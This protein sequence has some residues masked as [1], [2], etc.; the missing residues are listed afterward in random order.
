[1]LL[2]DANLRP[3]CKEI[4]EYE[5]VQ[6]QAQKLGINIENDFKDGFKASGR[7]GDSEEDV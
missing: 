4:L 7:F 1:M 2:V 5:S 6:R 3:S